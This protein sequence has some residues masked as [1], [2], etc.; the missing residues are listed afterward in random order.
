[1]RNDVTMPSELPSSSAIA[2]RL[3]EDLKY[4]DDQWLWEIVWRLNGEFPGV[5]I[6][7]K[8]SLAQEVTWQLFN[9]GKIEFLRGQWPDGA[10]G[11]LDE[12]GLRM[13]R[14]QTQPWHDPEEAEILV[15]LT[16]P[17]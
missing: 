7:D 5:D 15:L 4:E 2:A 3:I 6:A 1:M 13:I 14:E 16:L 12:E 9:D 17:S 11:P 10:V 8:V